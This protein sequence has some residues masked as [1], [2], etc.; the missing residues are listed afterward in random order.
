M[1]FDGAFLQRES[2]SSNDKNSDNTADRT[3]YR[4]SDK[5]NRSRI[6]AKL[7]SHAVGCAAI[8]KTDVKTSSA[9]NHNTKRQNSERR[10]TRYC[11]PNNR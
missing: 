1:G 9:P 4:T 3:A 10:S 6:F 5:T 8:A 7:L 11:H 2:L